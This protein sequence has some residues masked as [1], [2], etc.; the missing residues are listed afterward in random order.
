MA[1]D[2]VSSP[3]LC[4]ASM[5]RGNSRNAGAGGNTAPRIT[6]RTVANC[7]SRIPMTA[8]AAALSRGIGFINSI[9]QMPDETQNRH[10]E[11]EYER[12]GSGVKDPFAKRRMDGTE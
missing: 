6:K 11:R 12:A 8:S 1:S 3:S 7:T 5:E 2:C 10:A 9:D 4:Q